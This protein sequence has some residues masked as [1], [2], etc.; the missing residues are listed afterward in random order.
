MNSPG[1]SR[2]L[3]ALILI[4]VAYRAAAVAVLPVVGDEILVMAYGL[5]RAFRVEGPAALLLEVPI[6]V[7][8]AI[9]PLWFWLQSVP[10][11]VFG[12]LTKAGLRTLPFLF[13]VLGT[14]VAARAGRRLS[15]PGA[16]WWSGALYAVA[17][18]MVYTNSR[19]EF[20]ESLIAPALLALLLDLQPREDGAAPRYRALVWPMLILLLYLGKGI[21]VWATYAVYLAVLWLLARDGRVRT[22]AFGANRLALLVGF[23]LLP[24]LAFLT[25][26]DALLFRGGAR[27]VTEIGPIASVWDNVRALTLGYGAEVKS[28]MVAGWGEALYPFTDFETWPV[29][30]CLVVPMVAALAHL[31]RTLVAALVRREPDGLERSL[32]PIVLGVPA[33]M[34]T[35]FKGALQARVHLLYLVVLLPYA[36]AMIDRWVDALA[37]Q[38]HGRFLGWGIAAWLYVAWTLSWADR[39]Q[40]VWDPARF[41]TAAL[42]GTAV[43]IVTAGVARSVH[44]VTWIRTAASLLLTAA[45]LAAGAT[46][47]V[48][49]WGRRL[50]WE[51]GPRPEDMPEPVDLYPNPEFHLLAYYVEHETLVRRIAKGIPER[52]RE[53]SKA[54]RAE[55]IQDARPLIIEARAK[56]PDDRRTVRDAGMQ[57]F[58]HSPGDRE[59]VRSWWEDYLRRH[60]DDREMRALLERARTESRS[61]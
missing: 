48:L 8:N 2:T 30:A 11:A 5:T 41:A 17:S 21:V 7:S 35:V 45:L 31:G 22:R 49:D 1:G 4:A 24:P 60:P 15:G 6:T 43:L 33:L 19:G 27:V 52:D 34:T 55:V 16:A 39:Q 57:L 18:V 50:A 12:V 47:G 51:P 25:A 38:R 40:G 23:P 46:H 29:L 37:R 3:V 32:L 10:A 42:A 13:G 61:R 9:T 14:L 54:L 20:S 28:Y 59:L 56:H 44:R 26:A 53:R 36:A 58:V